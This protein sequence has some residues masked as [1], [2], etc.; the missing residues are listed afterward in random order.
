M[1][2]EELLENLKSGNVRVIFK[3]KDGK[4]RDM[5]CTLSEDIVPPTKGSNKNRN[6]NVL[7]VWDI[8]KNAWRSFRLDS[9][10]AIVIG[11]EEHA[12]S[13]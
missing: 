12:Y 4:F 5:L 10:K 6:E 1:R 2:L 7:P 11:E 13:R 9:I 3:K 8:K